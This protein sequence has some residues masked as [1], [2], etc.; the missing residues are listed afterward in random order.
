MCSKTVENFLALGITGATARIMRVKGLV[1]RDHARSFCLTEQGCAVPS[2][3]LDR[4]GVQ[5][6]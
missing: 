6:S 3:L 5:Q 1:E 4:S 2:A